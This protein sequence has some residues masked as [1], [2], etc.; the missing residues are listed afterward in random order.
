MKPTKDEKALLYHLIGYDIAGIAFV[1]LL[2]L[3]YHVVVLSPQY[4]ENTASFQLFRCRTLWPRH[5]IGLPFGPQE[6]INDFLWYS[7]F[8][9]AFS[10]DPNDEKDFLSVC[11]ELYETAYQSF[12]VSKP[13]KNWKRPYPHHI[14]DET[15]MPHYGRAF[16]KAVFKFVVDTRFQLER[17]SSLEIIWRSRNNSSKLDFM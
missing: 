14:K 10:G 4:G 3:S 16:W 2:A 1:K 7:H 15:A 13:T 11:L 5:F 9:K 17:K 6:S 8:L 12:A